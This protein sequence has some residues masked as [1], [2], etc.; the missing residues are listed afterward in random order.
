MGQFVTPQNTPAMP[1]AAVREEGS[2]RTGDSKAPNAAPMVKD[3]TIS[4]PLNPAP[5]VRAVNRI[6]S[7]KNKRA[8]DAA[9]GIGACQ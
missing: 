9:S 3:G 1:Q 8:A 6:F 2:P 5:K 4:P 7:R